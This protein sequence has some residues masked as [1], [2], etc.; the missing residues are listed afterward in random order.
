MKY[1]LKAIVSAVCLFSALENSTTPAAAAEPARTAALAVCAASSSNQLA[2]RSRCRRNERKISFADIRAVSVPGPQG[3]KGETGLQGPR[4]ETGAAGPQGP[5]GPVGPQ[6]DTGPAGPQGPRGLSGFSQ[7]PQG[8]T[9]YGVLGADY[10]AASA[11]SLWGTA[12]SFQA[13]PPVS[14]QD[15]LVAIANNT[16]VDN[17]CNGASCLDSEELPYSAHCSGTAENPTAPASFVCIYPSADLNA[18]G[19]RAVAIPRDN[20]RFGFFVRW[21]AASAGRNYFRAVWAYTAP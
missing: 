5:A 6:G 19:L 14:L 9:I 4:G 16:V 15:E 12:V 2:V 18:A 3:P 21:T 1:G 10:H 20:G 7:I 13:I 11:G 17:D 8:T